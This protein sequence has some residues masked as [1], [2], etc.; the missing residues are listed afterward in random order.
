MDKDGTCKLVLEDRTATEN[1]KQ[2]TSHYV[3]IPT[4]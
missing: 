2:M 1:D 3:K 4:Y